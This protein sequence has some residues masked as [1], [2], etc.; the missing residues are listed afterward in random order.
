[1]IELNID[2]KEINFSSFFFFFL[3][4]EI[5]E[6]I[7]WEINDADWQALGRSVQRK[8]RLRNKQL[9]ESS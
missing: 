4:V 7:S 5:D 9:M 3:L 8:V 1:M 2:R 6:R